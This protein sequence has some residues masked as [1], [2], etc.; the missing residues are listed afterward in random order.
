MN[1]S[2]MKQMIALNKAAVVFGLLVVIG[3]AAAQDVTGIEICTRETRLDRRTSCLQS[4]IEFLQQVIG[5]NGLDAQQKLTAANRDI[6]ALKDLLAIATRD[7]AALRESL[8]G[9]Q[10]R[11]DQIQKM[12]TSSKAEGKSDARPPVK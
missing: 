4:N 9:A 3:P 1:D 8:A 12:N 2:A 6:A 7:I 10:A 5:R 11:I